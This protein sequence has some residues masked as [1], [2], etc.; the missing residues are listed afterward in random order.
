VY[1]EPPRCSWIPLP[2]EPPRTWPAIC[3]R[4]SMPR[5]SSGLSRLRI[6]TSAEAQSPVAVSSHHLQKAAKLR[7]VAWVSSLSEATNERP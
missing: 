7:P 1:G 5:W 4:D 2:S 3:G 6:L